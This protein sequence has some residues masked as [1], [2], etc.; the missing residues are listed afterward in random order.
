MMMRFIELSHASLIPLQYGCYFV[1]ST[2]QHKL[3]S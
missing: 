2:Q 3:I 1:S